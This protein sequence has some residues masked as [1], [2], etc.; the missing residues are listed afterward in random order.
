[1]LSRERVPRLCDVVSRPTD[2]DHVLLDLDRVQIRQRIILLSHLRLAG[3]TSRQ[4]CL[5]LLS[6]SVCEVRAVI[7]V[8]CQAESALEAPDVVLEDIRIF[9]EVDRLS[10]SLRSRSLRSALVADCEATPPPPNFDP[11]LFW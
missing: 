10:A 6:L 2:L 9:V 7:L 11:A 4:I 1:M 5:M 3:R 8:D